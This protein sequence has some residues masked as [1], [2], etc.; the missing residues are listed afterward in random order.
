[1]FRKLEW[2]HPGCSSTRSREKAKSIDTD[3]AIELTTTKAT[4]RAST[5][6]TNLS[7]RSVPTNKTRSG[8]VTLQRVGS[9]AC[10]KGWVSAACV[11]Q[12]DPMRETQG[13]RE[14][15]QTGLRG[16]LAGADR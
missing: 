12:E 13:V 16:C 4:D 2:D 9:L 8:G 11:H 5:A 1:M 7:R 6:W 14:L 3:Q 15:G 10:V